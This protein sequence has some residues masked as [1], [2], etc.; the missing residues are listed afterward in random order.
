MTILGVDPGLNIFEQRR[1]AALDPSPDPL[2]VAPIEKMKMPSAPL[3]E[4]T[5]RAATVVPP[6]T[7]LGASRISTPLS[8]FSWWK[9]VAVRANTRRTSAP[10]SVCR[11]ASG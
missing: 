4:M 10:A 9:C 8:A 7:L 6:M 1:F 5:L 2:P 3:P 11:Y